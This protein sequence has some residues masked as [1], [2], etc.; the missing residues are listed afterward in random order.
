MHLYTSS[1]HIQQKTHFSMFL[2]A[3]NYGQTDGPTFFYRSMDSPEKLAHNSLTLVH[4]KSKSPSRFLQI[5]PLRRLR[6]ES[7][8]K[9][10]F[11][12][13]TTLTADLNEKAV[14][15]MPHESQ[16]MPHVTVYVTIYVTV[17]VTVHVTVK[18]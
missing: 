18:A 2:L 14:P 11:D 16:Y 17:H 13:S 4:L 9:G 1:E 8:L 7:Q 6:L 12:C 10:R 15:Y 5:R 3:M